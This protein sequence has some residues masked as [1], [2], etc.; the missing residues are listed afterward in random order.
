MKLK[1]IEALKQYEDR[2]MEMGMEANEA[3]AE[4]KHALSSIIGCDISDLYVKGAEY[5]T[6]TQQYR[7]NEVIKM[8]ATGKP[9]AYILGERWFMGL[10]FFVTPDE[11]C[12][13][14]RSASREI[15]TQ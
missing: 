6:D 15:T 7:M 4:A 2:F 10:K 1:R 11:M 9:L 3:A 8:R 5:V 13:R 12:I 14:D